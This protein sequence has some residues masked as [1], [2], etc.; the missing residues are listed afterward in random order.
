MELENAIFNDEQE[1]IIHHLCEGGIEKSAPQDHCL[2]SLRKPCDAKQLSPGR[3]FLSH[4][5]SH[6]EFLYSIPMYWLEIIL[7]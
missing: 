4:P 1:K 6:C 5:H 2:S 7:E 3:I